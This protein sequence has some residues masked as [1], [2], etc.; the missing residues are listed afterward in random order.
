MDASLAST[1]WTRRS[2]FRAS[3][4]HAAYEYEKQF[5]SWTVLSGYAPRLGEPK[6]RSASG[7]TKQTIEC[8]CGIASSWSSNTTARRLVRS[9]QYS[10]SIERS[11][12][13]EC[14]QRS[15]ERRV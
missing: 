11:G 10:L 14:R 6:Q 7:T 15:E 13:G 12:S 2:C 9:H 8:P 4:L 3:T 5:R 1:S